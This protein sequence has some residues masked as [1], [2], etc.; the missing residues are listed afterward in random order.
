MLP[1]TDAVKAGMV[2]WPAAV[3]EGVTFA[4][5]RLIDC[6]APKVVMTL[7]VNPTLS[8]GVALDA[9]NVSPVPEPK[10]ASVNVP[11]R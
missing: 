1:V 2:V 10:T 11:D 3:I 5:A 8:P 9:V 4:N 6:G 7:D